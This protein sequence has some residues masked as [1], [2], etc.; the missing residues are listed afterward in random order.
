[1]WTPPWILAV[2]A[3]AVWIGGLWRTRASVRERVLREEEF[4]V[5]GETKAFVW[6]EK[7]LVEVMERFPHSP[8]PV[9]AYAQHAQRRG[10]FEETL[11]RFQV[12]IKRNSKDARG[13]AGAAASLRGMGK[14][15]E[16]DALL[17]QADKRI[18]RR[19]ELQQ[20]FA[21]NAIKRQDWE[22][23][24]HLWA[25]HREYN[26]ED[27]M[28]YEQGQVALRKLGARRRPMPSPPSRRHGSASATWPTAPVD[29]SRAKETHDAID[30]SECRPG[31]GGGAGHRAGARPA[32]AGQ[33]GE[34]TSWR[35]PGAPAAISSSRAIC[36]RRTRCP[37][38]PALPP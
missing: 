27:R 13:Y 11:S 5:M 2:V 19:S 10:E 18:P 25:L 22:E 24:A 35:R 8:T 34:G 4:G 38:S 7:R 12:A 14:L 30:T 37:A 6:S 28:A 1:M 26:P 21:W 33:C 31:W 17:R 23:V 15:E 16:S 3:A 36:T 9:I 32:G 29:S 20:E